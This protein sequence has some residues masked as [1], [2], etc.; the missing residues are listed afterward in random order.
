MQTKFSKGVCLEIRSE[1]EIEN[2][3][4]Q[5]RVRKWLDYMPSSL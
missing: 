2:F 5:K 3:Q 1:L 4:R